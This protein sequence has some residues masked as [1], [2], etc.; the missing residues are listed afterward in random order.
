MVDLSITTD[1]AMSHVCA[2]RVYL[3]AM[4]EHFSTSGAC[5]LE[6]LLRVPEM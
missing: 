3:E 2:V 6:Q 5:W 4:P 1:L